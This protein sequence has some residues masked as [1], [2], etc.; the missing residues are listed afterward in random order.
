MKLENE[1][2]NNEDGDKVLQEEF[3]KLQMENSSYKQTIE[4]QSRKEYIE[5]SEIH[6]NMKN[7]LANEAS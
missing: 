4:L 2:R 7:E 6:M 5:N 1:K 3:Q